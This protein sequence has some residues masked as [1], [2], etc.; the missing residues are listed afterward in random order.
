MKDLKN[1]IAVSSAFN[2]Q[3][4][5]TDTVTDGN[6]IDLLDNESCTFI[7]QTGVV[8][9]GTATPIIEES[10]A[11]TFTGDENAVADGDLIGTELLAIIDTTSEVKTIAYIGGKRFVRFTIDSDASADLTVGVSA[12]LGHG[13]TQKEILNLGAA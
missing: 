1:D 13:L 6:V 8:T 3:L 12:V 11:N 9:A 10:D 7:I 2:T 4:I 5:N